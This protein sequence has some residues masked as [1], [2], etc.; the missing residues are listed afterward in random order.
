MIKMTRVA[1]VGAAAAGLMPFFFFSSRRRHTRSLRDWSSDVCSSDLAQHF[2][3]APHP[4][5]KA[6]AFL[7]KFRPLFL[8]GSRHGQHAAMV[9]EVLAEIGR[10]SCRERALSPVDAVPPA[11][12][13][14]HD[15]NDPRCHRGRG[16][17]RADAVLFFFKQ[18]TA[19]EIST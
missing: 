12:R 3:L 13:T 18:K 8:G 19:Y 7:G 5:D 11:R 4:A 10:A 15:Q 14:L 2:E 16:R 1:T 17:R 9:L 6:P